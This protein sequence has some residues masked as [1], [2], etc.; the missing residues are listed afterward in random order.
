MPTTPNVT[1]PSTARVRCDLALKNRAHMIHLAA[2]IMKQITEGE[3]AS[4]ALFPMMN[5]DEV[6]AAIA[7]IDRQDGVFA[8]AIV[9]AAFFPG[10]SD[11]LRY[12][13]D[14]EFP[15]SLREVTATA[16]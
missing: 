12:E 11:A 13:P 16:Q 4:R 7:E 1:D 8:D 14:P 3:R 6:A 9:G 10:R 15:G 2:E 5:P